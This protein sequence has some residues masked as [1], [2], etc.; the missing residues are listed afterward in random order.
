MKGYFHRCSVGACLMGGLGD[1]SAVGDWCTSSEIIYMWKAIRLRGGR[2][3]TKGLGNPS[4]R[5]V[6]SSS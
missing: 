2:I 4:S 1:E 3:A 6:K 5:E